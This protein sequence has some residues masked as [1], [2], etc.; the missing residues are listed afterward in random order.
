MLVRMRHET[1][2]RFFGHVLT[3]PRQQTAFN[4]VMLL[5]G[6]SAV[7]WS[8]YDW[9]RIRTWRRFYRVGGLKVG[10]VGIAFVLFSALW[11]L[12]MGR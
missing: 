8:Y 2:I 4:V 5:L 1:T 7:F 3:D 9:R 10:I 11:L 12:D 6:L